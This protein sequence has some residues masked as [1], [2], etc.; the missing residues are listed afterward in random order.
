MIKNI[1]MKISISSKIASPKIRYV[2]SHRNG[3]LRP[4]VAARVAVIGCTVGVGAAGRALVAAKVVVI[5]QTGVGAGARSLR[6]VGGKYVD[7]KSHWDR[8]ATDCEN[9]AHVHRDQWD[10]VHVRTNRS[11]QNGIRQRENHRDD[12][13]E[14]FGPCFSSSDEAMHCDGVY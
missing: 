3:D 6:C 9:Y 14:M 12:H 2:S 10:H 7:G 5:G 4:L 13:R 1:I 11:V 8:Q